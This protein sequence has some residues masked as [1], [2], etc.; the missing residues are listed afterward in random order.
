MTGRLSIA[1]S[2]LF[3]SLAEKFAQIAGAGFDGVELHESDF[4][5]FDGTAADVVAMARD[6]ALSIFLLAPFYDLEGLGGAARTR[7][8]DRLEAKFDLMQKLGVDTLLVGS[9]THPDASGDPETV[10][11]DLGDLA[12]RAGA[13]GVR[14]AYLALPWARHVTTDTAALSLIR[15]V[16]SPHL[17]VAL[18]SYFALADGSRPARL[19]D[20]DGARVFHVQLSDAPALDVDIRQLKR[21]FGLLPGQGQLNLAGFVRVLARAGYGG[22]WSIPRIPDA[23]TASGAG[24]NA[25]DAYRA[26]VNLLDEVARSDRDLDLGQPPLP[27]RVRTTGFEFIEFTAGAQGAT[28]TAMLETMAFRMERRHISKSVELWRQGGINIVLNTEP[29]GFAHDAYLKHGPSVCDM[30]LRVKNARQTVE[31][32]AALGAE[33]F[34]Q[35]VGTGELDIPAVRSVGGNVVHFIDEASNL[36]RVW[37]IEFEPVARTVASRPAGLRRID[38]IAQTMSQDEMQSWLLYYIS[39][40]EMGKST[41]VNVADPSGTVLS[42]TIESPEGAVRLNLNGAG[43]ERTFAGSFLAGH[44]SAGVQHIAFLSDDI[45]ET[46]ERLRETGFRSLRIS[47]NYYDDLALTFDIAPEM[48]ENMKAANI[49]YDREGKGEYFQIYSEPIF[50]GFFFEIVERRGGYAGYGARNAPIRL[51]AQRRHFTPMGDVATCGPH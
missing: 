37:D 24:P 45:F 44:F 35:P 50:G 20:I 16:D 9:S 7:A 51:A 41:V 49:L 32:A 3:G 23:V 1:T 36:H 5:G 19:R 17:G 25:A 47:D 27:A 46:A 15:R 10:A 18:S 21:Q 43:S 22:V 33:T 38:H 4:T 13:R 12:D 30:G 28:L 26:L 8:F 39:T 34:S 48:V 40:F 42:Q 29:V 6:H 14:V 11:A 31:R 2:A